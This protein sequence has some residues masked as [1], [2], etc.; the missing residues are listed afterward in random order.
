MKNVGILLS[1]RGSNFLAL[2]DSVESG[3]VEARIAMV[4]SNCPEA[5][6]L[7]HAQARNYPVRCMPSLNLDREQFDLKVAEELRSADID[8]VCLAGFMRILGPSF[9]SLYPHRILN[10][11]PSLLP[12]F[13]GLHAQRQALNWGAKIAGCTVHF[14]DEK[15]DHGPIILQEAIPV[16]EEDTE[17]T[18]S[19]RIL[20]LEHKIYPKAL[21]LVCKERVQVQGRRVLTHL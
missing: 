9:I 14:V 18:L 4:I 5:P 21:K 13:P 1:G 17:E 6:G 16:L 2:A 7:R 11:H 8:I 20:K 3:K 15:L 12:A 19:A 10:I